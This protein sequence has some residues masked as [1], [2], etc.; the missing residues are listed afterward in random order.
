[1]NIFTPN[2]LN[3]YCDCAYKYYLNYVRDVKIPQNDIPFMV[4]KNVHALASYYLKGEDISKYDLP[5]KEAHLWNNLMKIEYMR[6]KPVKVE[7]SILVKVA[8]NW[9]GGRVDAVVVDNQ[10]NYYILDYKTG[11]IPQDYKYAFQTMIYSLGC[12][13]LFDDINT[14]KFV[15]INVRDVETKEVLFTESLKSE[16]ETRISDVISSIKK[17]SFSVRK[18]SEKCNTCQYQKVCKSI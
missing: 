14:L 1:M 7:Q 6:M 15:Y 10:N 11:N 12:N 4:G 2:M 3:I 13:S 8:D 9:V 18:H 17:D 5:P 16:Y